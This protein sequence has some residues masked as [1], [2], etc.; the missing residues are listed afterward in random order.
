MSQVEELRFKDKQL[1]SG[2]VS[3][4]LQTVYGKGPVI[5]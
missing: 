1:K 5:S 4:K 2:L 3:W